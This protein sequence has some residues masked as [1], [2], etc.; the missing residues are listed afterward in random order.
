[1]TTRTPVVLYVY[2]CAKCGQDGQLH[3]EETAPEV[4]TA[5]SMCGAKVLAEEGTREH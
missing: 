2:H 5:C 3:L 1:M 4:T